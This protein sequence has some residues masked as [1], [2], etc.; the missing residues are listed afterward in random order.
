MY[1]TVLIIKITELIIKMPV[2]FFLY[3]IIICRYP[4][5]FATVWFIMHFRV[6]VHWKTVWNYEKCSIFFL[7]EFIPVRLTCN[8]TTSKLYY[9]TT[10]HLNNQ[11]TVQP[12]HFTPLQPANCTTGPLYTCT[13]SKL[14]YLTTVHLHN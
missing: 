1:T 2:Y 12:D 4:Y 5:P 7:T 10:E 11:Q 3:Y 8:C 9:L 14:Y 6:H 13:T